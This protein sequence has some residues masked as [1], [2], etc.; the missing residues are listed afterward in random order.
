MPRPAP[1][2]LL[3][4]LTPVLLAAAGTRPAALPAQASRPAPRADHAI[5]DSLL[6]AHVVDGMVDYDAFARSAAFGRYL[7]L[8]ARTDVEALPR[9]ERLALWIN[10]YNAYTIRLVVAHGERE[11]IRNI[12]RTLGL[13]KLKGP[14]SEPIARVGGRTYTLDD[15]EHR[16]IRPAFREPRIH[17]AL[18]C[19]A[20]GCPPLR[21]EAYTGPRLDR[22]LQEQGELFIRRSPAKNRVDLA[23]RTLH[24]S[25]V[26]TYYDEDFGG[27]PEGV[28]RYVARWYPEGSAERRML[29]SGD[30]RL[31]QTDYDWTLNSQANARRARRGS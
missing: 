6:R 30:F 26:F 11:S 4:W 16:I 7:E 9:D 13:L 14:W 25:L 28:G 10:A 24:A 20:M 5:L 23:T 12:N 19:A 22:Q 29:E 31:V 8:L 3:A 27:K 18:V 1:R 17:F 2:R 15:I 21:S